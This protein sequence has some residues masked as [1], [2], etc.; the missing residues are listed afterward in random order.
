MKSNCLQTLHSAIFKLFRRLVC[1]ASLS[2]FSPEAL[3][4]AVNSLEI[5]IHERPFPRL[6]YHD[7]LIWRWLAERLS[8][9]PDTRKA[10]SGIGVS[11]CTT[12][13]LHS[14]NEQLSHRKI[15]P[16]HAQNGISEPVPKETPR[17]QRTVPCLPQVDISRFQGE[18]FFR[19]E[20]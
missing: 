20:R 18:E 7:L 5:L 6:E 9:N 1:N 11:R 19:E 3:P 4:N 2:K 15:C 14:E 8:E 12:P 17:R 16:H 13:V 10:I